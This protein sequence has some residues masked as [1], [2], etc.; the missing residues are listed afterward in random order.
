M[1]SSIYQ[2]TKTNYNQQEYSSN[3]SQPKIRVRRTPD[4]IQRVLNT[5]FLTGTV[6]YSNPIL[7]L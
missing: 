3:T 1:S 7:E 5:L 4:P 2:A 6:L